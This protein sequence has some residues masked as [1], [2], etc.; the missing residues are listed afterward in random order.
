[1]EIERIRRGRPTK[2]DG[3]GPRR[4]EIAVRVSLAERDAIRGLARANRMSMSDYIRA[5]IFPRGKL[6]DSDALIRLTALRSIAIERV[7]A[8]YAPVIEAIVRAYTG[9]ESDTAEAMIT[10][11][12]RVLIAEYDQTLWQIDE[13]YKAYIDRAMKG[14]V[15]NPPTFEDLINPSDKAVH[16]PPR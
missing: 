1:M 12:E 8:H 16:L 14:D 9:R 11:S 6:R 13:R 7:H 10:A 2:R 5:L 3:E 4:T 15:E